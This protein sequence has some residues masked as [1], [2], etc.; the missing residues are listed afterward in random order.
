MLSVNIALEMMMRAY[1]LN[2]LNIISLT[3]VISEAPIFFV[4]S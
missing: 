1:F 4:L 2:Y 3:F